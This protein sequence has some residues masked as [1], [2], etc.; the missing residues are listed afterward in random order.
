MS[1]P[2]N[3]LSRLAHGTGLA[4]LRHVRQ[5]VDRLTDDLREHVE[6]QH[7]LADEMTHL[8]GRVAEVAVRRRRSR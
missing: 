5:R 3:A 6:L 8:E 7:R 2:R 4:Q 1:R